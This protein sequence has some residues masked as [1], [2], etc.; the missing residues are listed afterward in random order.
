M[1]YS[2]KE[3]SLI[4]VL[5]IVGFIMMIDVSNDRK[6]DF[7][8]CTSTLK[9][10]LEVERHYFEYYAGAVKF[11]RESQNFDD[12]ERYI[13]I[14]NKLFYHE[15][16]RLL[17]LELKEK[18]LFKN[19]SIDRYRVY[20]HL[21]DYKRLGLQQ[22][23]ETLQEDHHISDLECAKICLLENDSTLATYYLKKVNFDID[24]NMLSLLK[25]KD[26]MSLMYYQR[27]QV[28]SLALA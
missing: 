3:V 9:C 6:R 21:I 22:V 24:E 18:L 27:K 12:L 23:V 13:I 28:K 4:E 15:D 7:S 10:Q 17:K 26:I 8:L 14:M 5:D 16:Y 1:R 20:R 25:L 2:F 11:V 19:F